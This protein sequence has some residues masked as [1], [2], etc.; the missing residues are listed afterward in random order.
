MTIRNLLGKWPL[1]A[2][3]VM[4]MA[5]APTATFAGKGVI[6]L[7]EGDWTG[8]LVFSKLAQI[9]LEDEMDYTVKMIFLPAGPAVSE[10]IIGGEIDVGFESWPS[11]S[12]TKDVYIKEWGGDGS[13]E[14]F[15]DTGIIGQSGWYV[16]RYVIEG[17][18]A[19]GIEAVAPDLKTYAQLNQ[20]KDIFMAPETSPKGRLVACP[21][22]AWQCMDTQRVEGLGLDYEAVE[23]G[24]EMAHWAELDAA[25]AR[26]DPILVYAWEPHWVHAKYDLVE[27]ELPEYSD[28]AWPAA[29]WPQDITYHYGSPN[30]KGRY[31]DVHQFLKNI[32]LTNAQQAGMILDVDV[33]GMD[34]DAAVRKWMA[35]NEDIWRAWIPITM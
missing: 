7:H 25:Y 21:V 4:A 16:P 1:L 28:E 27:V 29:D 6:K 13:I 30:L 33:N 31:P 26:G 2:A 12:T 11:Y 9:I 8:N 24:S 35:A 34:L 22:A 32:H 20:Y 5:V 3:V 19:R 18:A 23:L 17:D 14:K 15:T 10:A